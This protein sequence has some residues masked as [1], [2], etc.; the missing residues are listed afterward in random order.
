[1]NIDQT[2]GTNE[3]AAAPMM[4]DV[5]ALSPQQFAQLGMAKLAYVK[6]VIV[7]GASGFAIHAA[8]GTPMAVAADRDVAIAAI[9][10]H[11]MMPALV[12]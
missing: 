10:Q 11:E 8:D 1:M 3:T 7:D 12:H 6:P 9:V 4:V 2:N 5:R